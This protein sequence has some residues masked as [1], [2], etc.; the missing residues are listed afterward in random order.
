LFLQEFAEVSRPFETVRERFTG[1]GGWFAPLATAA[2][3][4]G[5]ELY[6]RIGPSWASGRAARKVRVT[7]GQ[8]HERGQVLVVPLSWQS[9]ELRGLFPVLD[10]DMELAPVEADRCR[11]TLSASY[12]PPFGELGRQL[13]RAVL[14][15]V[16]RST[17]RSFLTRV[18]ASLELAE[19]GPP[20]GKQTREFIDPLPK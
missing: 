12:A 8:P 19:P 16:A 4:D 20:V 9:S 11:L 18:A 17:V 5:E 15:R 7:L 2:E 10:G 13:D 1:D 6:I 14:H 3:E